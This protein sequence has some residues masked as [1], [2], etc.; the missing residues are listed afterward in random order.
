MRQRV[1]NCSDLKTKEQCDPSFWMNVNGQTHLCD[2]NPSRN[3]CV[4]G[5]PCA[6]PTAP[7]FL[8]WIGTESGSPTECSDLNRDQCHYFKHSD[9]RRCVLNILG[10]CTDP[11]DT[12]PMC[13]SINLEDDFAVSDD[14]CPDGTKDNCQNICEKKNSDFTGRARTILEYKCGTFLGYGSGRYCMCSYPS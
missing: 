8:N 9:D 2:W 6:C 13:T 4:Y 12:E 10:E 5:P 1:N 14:N 3:Q 7:F 11:P